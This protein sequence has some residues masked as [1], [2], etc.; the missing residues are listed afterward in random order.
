MQ[1]KNIPFTLFV[2]AT[3]LVCALTT[4]QAALPETTEA[5]IHNS[6]SIQHDEQQQQQQQIKNE[7][8]QRAMDCLAK[9]TNHKIEFLKTMRQY[10][11]K[12]YAFKIEHRNRIRGLFRTVQDDRKFLRSYCGH[13]TKN[14]CEMER[15]RIDNIRAK[16]AEEI[17]IDLATRTTKEVEI[18]LDT[19]IEKISHGKA[20]D[21]D[22]RQ[23]IE[24]INSQ[25]ALFDDKNFVGFCN[26]YAGKIKKKLEHSKIFEGELQQYVTNLRKLLIANVCI[27]VEGIEKGEVKGVKQQ[28]FEDAIQIVWEDVLQE[29]GFDVDIVYVETVAKKFV[30]DE[31]RL[32]RRLE[33]R[34][35]GT[36]SVRVMLGMR[37]NCEEK[38]P[39]S[40]TWGNRRRKLEEEIGLTTALPSTETGEKVDEL[41]QVFVEIIFGSAVTVQSV[42]CSSLFFSLSDSN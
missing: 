18:L 30:A 12:R 9:F 8:Q 33:L 38:D 3:I 29:E 4:T 28:R 2:F 32:R 27:E 6:S 1:G 10:K 42:P 40:D 22:L 11:N 14:D 19:L 24:Y 34:E 13:H 41:L 25:K 15:T 16:K 21:V 20:L 39:L 26:K 36:Q 31:N 5:P 23:E 35:T 7:I 17:A 37:C